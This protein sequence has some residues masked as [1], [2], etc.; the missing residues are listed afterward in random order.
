VYLKAVSRSKPPKRTELMPSFIVFP[1][2]D[3]LNAETQR[4]REDS[5]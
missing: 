1:G 3:N 2:Q 4:R 5:L